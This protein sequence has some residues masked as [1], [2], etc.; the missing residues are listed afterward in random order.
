MHNDILNLVALSACGRSAARATK[1]LQSSS[2]L[3]SLRLK[4]VLSNP[5]LLEE[6]SNS[7]FFFKH[8]GNGWTH[9]WQSTIKCSMALHTLNF[10]LD[11]H[12]LN[13]VPF[14]VSF[15]FADS[16]FRKGPPRGPLGNA[17]NFLVTLFL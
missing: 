7:L 13:L 15:L 1:T 3:H 11:K 2:M 4:L 5:F 8:L 12:I 10:L 17:E 16:S 14:I 9:T 6:M